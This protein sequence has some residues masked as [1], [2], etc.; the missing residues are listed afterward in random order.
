MMRISHFAN[1]RQAA[2]TGFRGANPHLLR[3]PPTISGNYQ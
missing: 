1:F 3:E 2:G